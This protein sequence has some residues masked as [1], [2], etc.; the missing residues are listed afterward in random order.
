[1]VTG[2]SAFYLS[3]LFK[4]LFPESCDTD[5]WNKKHQQNVC[6][7]HFSM[8]FKLS[9]S[10]LNFFPNVFEKINCKKQQR[11]SF[12]IPF[13]WMQDRKT[14]VKSGCNSIKVDLRI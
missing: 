3:K 11:K 14:V 12:F 13:L 5:G 1:M 9:F 2:L 6:I 10:T 8:I 4:C 7:F